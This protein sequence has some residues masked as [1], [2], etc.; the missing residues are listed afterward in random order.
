MEVI[1]LFGFE[2]KY[3]IME[4]D[5]FYLDFGIKFRLVEDLEYINLREQYWLVLSIER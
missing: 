1:I 3:W 2:Y 5:I 4:F